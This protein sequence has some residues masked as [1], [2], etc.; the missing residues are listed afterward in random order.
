MLDERVHNY[1]EGYEE[2]PWCP[3]TKLVQICASLAGV[4]LTPETFCTETIK[5]AHYSGRA[6]QWLESADFHPAASCAK[7]NHKLLDQL[8]LVK[9]EISLTPDNIINRELDQ[10]K[11]FD[12]KKTVVDKYKP[13]REHYSKR[14]ETFARWRNVIFETCCSTPDDEKNV[15]FRQIKSADE[16]SE[17]EIIEKVEQFT[18]SLGEIVGYE[19]GTIG[20]YTGGVVNCPQS[21]HPGHFGPFTLRPKY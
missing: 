3:S 20:F 13:E 12:A 15:H 21:P 16:L 17:A 2:K 4:E 14:Q 10:M 7:I 19:E 11:S 8:K 1:P 9:E 18:Q 6:I 5:N